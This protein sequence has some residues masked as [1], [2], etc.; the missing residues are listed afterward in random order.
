MG[1]RH[2]FSTS[3][4][5]ENEHQHWNHMHG[6]QPYMHSARTTAAENGS[7]VHPVENMSIDGVHFS[8]H[9]NTTPRS[10]GYSSS[11]HN[12]EVPH[13]RTD[14]SGPSHDPFLHPSAAGSFC[15]A[16]DN[17]AYHASSSNYERQ[18]FHGIEGGFIDHSLGSVRGPYKRKSPGIPAVCERGSSSRY[19]SAGSSSD[20]SISSDSRQDKPNTDCQHSF[21]DPVTMTSCYRGNSL[22]IGGES[23]LRNVRSRSA[24]DLE[25]NL[26]RTHLSSNQLHHPYAAGYPNDH[27]SSVDLSGQSSVV[28]ARE[29]NQVH[30]SHAAHGRAP[31]SDASGLNHEPM[32][33]LVGSST[34]NASVDIGGYHHDFISSRNPIQQNFIGTSSQCLRGVR[35]SYSQRSTPTFRASSSSL[36]LGQV[37]VSDEGMQLVAENYSSRHPRPLPIVGWRNGDRSGRSRMSNERYRSLSDEAGVRDRLAS[38]GLM[39]VDRAALYSSRNLFDQHREMR[40]DID[41]MSYEEL[42]ALGERIGNVS[43]GLSEDLISKCLT[44]TIYCSSDQIQEEGTCVICLEEYKNMDDV[45]AL[46]ICGHDYHVGCIKQWLSMKNSCPICKATALVDNM[47]GK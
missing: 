12:I 7:L 16:A 3:Q 6:E 30:V 39:F 24:L 32:H 10:N 9:W 29:W 46:K 38:E 22:S 13:Y 40:L 31:V 5:F 8:S 2:L 44:E 28:S 35:S 37:G 42:L 26:A 21:W 20:L 27:P 41:N 23:S 34:G 1:H 17:Y 36:R 47:N 4:M 25:S 18:T 43:T 11:S 45:G 14:V 15:V 19:F 33:F